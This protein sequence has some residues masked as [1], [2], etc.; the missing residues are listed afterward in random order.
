MSQY[1]AKYFGLFQVT[2]VRLNIGYE[3][4]LHYGNSLHASRIS[5][6]VNQYLDN[7]THIVDCFAL[8]ESIHAA[9]IQIDLWYLLQ[10]IDSII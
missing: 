6:V 10:N 7:T 9:T 4:V 5:I 2:F 8:M 3:H 1:P